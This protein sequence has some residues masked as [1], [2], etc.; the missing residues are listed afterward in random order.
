MPGTDSATPGRHPT[1]PDPATGT[2]DGQ[3]PTTDQ[4]SVTL[5]HTPDLRIP[6]NRLAVSSLRQMPTH[7]GVAFVADLSIDGRYAGPIENDGNGGPTEY[8]GLNSSPFTW[9]DLHAYVQACRYRGQPASEEQ[10]L[11]A[12][13]DFTDR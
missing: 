8:F 12:L 6:H 9:Q 10:V 4:H 3:V 13:V 1:R 11:Q 7:N 2:A 5:V